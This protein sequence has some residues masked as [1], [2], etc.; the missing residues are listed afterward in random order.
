M[1]MVMGSFQKMTKLSVY[2]AMSETKGY[3][4]MEMVKGK[5][6]KTEKA[7]VYMA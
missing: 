6:P 7:K 1:E 3:T 2:K 5:L 4:A